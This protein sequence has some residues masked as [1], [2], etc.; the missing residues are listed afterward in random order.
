MHF[1]THAVCLHKL[2]TFLSFYSSNNKRKKGQPLQQQ[3]VARLWWQYSFPMAD[4]NSTHVFVGNHFQQTAIKAL[5]LII[6]STWNQSHKSLLVSNAVILFPFLY[7][8]LFVSSILFL[9][10]VMMQQSLEGWVVTYYLAIGPCDIIAFRLFL[11]PC[12]RLLTSWLGFLE[13]LWFGRLPFFFFSLSLL[14]NQVSVWKGKVEASK[15]NPL[16]EFFGSW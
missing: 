12:V 7:T 3:R 5:Q 6:Q 1:I 14:I 15:K 2:L 11:P 8:F 13:L 16:R 4:A 9:T 10:L